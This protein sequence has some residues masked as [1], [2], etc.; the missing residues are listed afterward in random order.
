VGPE[1]AWARHTLLIHRDESHR[2]ARVG[3]WVRRGLERG[4]R[5]FYATVAG[6]TH[7]GVEL[8]QGGVDVPRAVR[9]GQL[10]FVPSEEFFPGAQ[11][12]TLVRRALAEGYA[13]VRLS[14]RADPAIRDVG[15]ERFE[16]IDHVME[17]LCA[18]LPVLVLCQYDAVGATGMADAAGLTTAVDSHLDAFQDGQMRVQR[19]GDLVSVGGEVDLVS[20]DVLAHALR[21]MVRP[22]HGSE[23]V[24]D[25]AE[26]AF[27]D[28]AGCRA[29]V[30]GTEAVRGDGGTV[31][32][33][34]VS[35]H[36][37]KLMALLRID[38]Q[39]GLELA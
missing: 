18:T 26:L 25:L 36:V 32:L 16:V 21:R 17:E 39:P 23:M 27:V 5:I 24:I 13:G 30:T 20:A 19:R 7:Q 6:D 35:G 22:G 29:L 37:H 28:V 31:F 8:R 33:R 34:G 38:R 1:V 2:R 14:A 10:T 9:D 11:Q 4:E 15:A 3:A 12:A